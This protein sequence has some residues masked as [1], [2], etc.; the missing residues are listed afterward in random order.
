MGTLQKTLSK[1]FWDVD[2]NNLDIK[3]SPFFVIQRILEHGDEKAVRWMLRNF[4]SVQI[5][6]VL[7]KT[8]G[9]SAKSANYW[10]LVFNIPKNKILCLNRSYQKMQKSH[11]PY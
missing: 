5:K 6:K 4:D 9:F 10:S 3:K 7:S 11:W 2:F 1:Y 8:K